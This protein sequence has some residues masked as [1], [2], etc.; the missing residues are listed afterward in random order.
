MILFSNFSVICP[1]PDP[2]IIVQIGFSGIL[3]HKNFADLSKFNIVHLLI[4]HIQHLYPVLY[5][6]ELVLY[7]DLS[8][9]II[10]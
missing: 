10:F 1:N 8:I 4:V 3:S 9:Q 5:S 6:I 7:I 2:K